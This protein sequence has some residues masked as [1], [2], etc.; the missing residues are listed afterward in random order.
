MRPERKEKVHNI[1]KYLLSVLKTDEDKEVA[2]KLYEKAKEKMARDEDPIDII[3]AL[4]NEA[5]QE[6]MRRIVESN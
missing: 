3:M 6:L 1:F 5:K 4:R 2:S